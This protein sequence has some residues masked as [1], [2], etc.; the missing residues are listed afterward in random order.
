M[1][2]FL[3]DDVLIEG[4][5]NVRRAV[6]SHFSSHFQSCNAERPNIKSLQRPS[7]SYRE[8]ASLVKL[9]SMEEVKA[10]VWDCDNYKCS[11]PDDITFGFIKDFWEILRDNVMQ[12]FVE[13]NRNGRLTKWINSTFIALIP[14]VD[15]SQQLNDFRLFLWW[16]ACIKF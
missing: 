8:G 2:Y 1:S 13:F 4:V 9:F 6:F 3:V 5:E 7:F 16:E 14:K 11:S 10:A 12:F 15:N